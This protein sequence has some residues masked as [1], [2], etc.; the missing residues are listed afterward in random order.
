MKLPGGIDRNQFVVFIMILEIT[1]A[2][3]MPPPTYSDRV[4]GRRHCSN[5]ATILSL[6]PLVPVPPS[7]T[8]V[9]FGLSTVPNERTIDDVDGNR[10]RF[11]ERN[12]EPPRGKR[13]LDRNTF[14][15]ISSVTRDDA[16]D[17]L[18]SPRKGRE[19]WFIFLQSAPE[20]HEKDT[21]TGNPFL[22]H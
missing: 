7:S 9:I 22:V 5:V 17:G 1:Y 12:N 13:M 2:E 20:T 10:T 18:R 4:K 3:A 16:A 11:V 21:K 15:V 19:W 6:R 8:D 14:I